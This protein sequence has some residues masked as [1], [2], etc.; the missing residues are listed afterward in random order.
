MEQQIE[1][2]DGDPKLYELAFLLDPAVTEEATAAEIDKI[3]SLLEAEGG[4]IESSGTPILRALS[5]TIEKAMSGKRYKY[6]Q[7][8]FAWVKFRTL[9]VHIETIE[10]GLIKMP[11][12]VRHMILNSTLASTTPAPRRYVKKDANPTTEAPEEKK[13]TEEQIEKEVEELI[14]STNTVTANVSK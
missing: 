3:T 8:Y 13:V 4:T 5:Y 2:N 6:D 7:A 11:S 12:L 1:G 9:P 14:A 10:Q